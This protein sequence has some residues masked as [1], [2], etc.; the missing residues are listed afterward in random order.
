M[1]RANV[2][3]GLISSDKVKLSESDNI[4]DGVYIKATDT[5]GT[6]YNWNPTFNTPVVTIIS[7]S[8]S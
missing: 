7:R 4:L 6:A 3:G 1:G 2:G 5:T 8:R